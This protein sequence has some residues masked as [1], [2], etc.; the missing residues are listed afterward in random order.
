VT[1]VKVGDWAQVQISWLPEL[2]T[3]R[4][5][6]NRLMQIVQITETDAIWRTLELSDAGPGVAISGLPVLGALTLNGLFVNAPVTSVP[7]GGEARVDYAIGAGAPAPDS[8]LWQQ[9]ARLSANGTAVLGP[10]VSGQTV[11]VR[12]RG[13][14]VGKRRSAWTAGS[15][16]TLA[17]VP[18]VT[19]PITVTFDATNAPT[20]NVPV[21]AATLGVRFS[22]AV[23]LQTA[24]FTGTF[25]GTTDVAVAAGVATATLPVTVPFGSAIAVMATPYSGFAA[26]AVT[27]T[28]GIASETLIDGNFGIG[29]A[30]EPVLEEI[31]STT[32]TVGTLTI[33]VTDPQLRL[34]KMEFAHQSGNGA[35]SAWVQDSVLPY[36]DSVTI[37]ESQGGKIAYRATGYDANGVL[38]ILKTNEISFTLGN[39]PEI[40]K[41]TLSIDPSGHLIG[42]LTGDSRTGSFV[43]NTQNGSDPSAVT[44]RAGVVL[45]GRTVV[46][47]FGAATPGIDYHVG[48]FA[49]TGTGATGAESQ[50]A[51]ARI[52]NLDVSTLNPMPP[53]IL[54]TRSAITA[55]TVSTETLTISGGAG[56]GGT[57]FQYRVRTLTEVSGPPAWGAFSASPALPQEM[58]VTRGLKWTKTVEVQ[59]TDATGKITTD[60]H[61][62]ASKFDAMNDSGILNDSVPA[63]SGVLLFRRT[64]DSASDVVTTTTR[65]FVDPNAATQVDASGRIVGVYRLGVYEPVNNLVKVGD[66]ISPSSLSVSGATTLSGNVTFGQFLLGAANKGIRIGNSFFGQQGG[67]Y[68][69][70]GYNNSDGA[71]NQNYFV[72]DFASRIRF[73]AGGISFQTA[74]SGT[75]GGAIT[76]TERALLTAAQFTLNAIFL[77]S[78]SYITVGVSA[79]NGYIFFGTDNAY[80]IQRTDPSWGTGVMYTNGSFR[81]AIRT[82]SDGSINAGGQLRATGWW[83]SGDSVGWGAELG[84]SGAGQIFLYA[85]NRTTGVYGALNFG[86]TSYVFQPGGDI[87]MGGNLILTAP[88]GW[89]QLIAGTG[90]NG[91]YINFTNTGGNYY[92]GVD[93]SAGTSLGFGGYGIGVYTPAGVAW[94]ISKTSN[95]MTFTQQPFV[96]I[97]GVTT[98]PVACY[99]IST[100]APTTETAPEGT[101]WIQT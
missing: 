39:A 22:Y 100:S 94:W 93:N 5:S 6:T 92:F 1:A 50:A 70:V 8:G 87:T 55:P 29:E 97:S 95:V 75:A 66:A 84:V 47:D 19:G 44:I 58:A 64:V 26:G 30:I 52:T 82:L 96:A 89:I 31:S 71:G 78:G 90:T 2:T 62:V 49:Y 83:T 28:A 74:P 81:S 38:R 33:Q 18:T 86:G 41:I 34:T 16:I 12:V 72:S 68:G 56:T 91:A 45:N 48:V 36:A 11:W 46:K 7:A 40:P 32:G 13:E 25:T 17:S 43:T 15:S 61:V 85:Y 20:V 14:I 76:F 69:E 53:I 57:G 98:R 4:L 99:I 65:T 60:K 9:G 35:W 21:N 80:Y 42:T 79:N 101:L 23:I 63:S 67:G 59:A 3:G 27:G 51:Y 10:F 54:I 88:A 24:D 73:T 37:S 77:V